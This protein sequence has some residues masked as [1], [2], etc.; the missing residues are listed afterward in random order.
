[1]TMFNNLFLRKPI[2]GLWI[3]LHRSDLFLA[4]RRGDLFKNIIE[5]LPHNDRDIIEISKK[6]KVAP[7]II[8]ARLQ[9]KNLVP[10]SFGNELKLGVDLFLKI[11]QA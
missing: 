9:Y 1:M 2:L 11:K 10:K 3:Q 6:I 8:V 4:E 7:G 5:N